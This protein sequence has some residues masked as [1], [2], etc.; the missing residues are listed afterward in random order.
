MSDTSN[1]V[2]HTAMANK[3]TL[4]SVT[5]ETL[6]KDS[7]KAKVSTNGPMDCYIKEILMRE[8]SVGM[9]G[10]PTA[11]NRIGWYMRVILKMG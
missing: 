5:L 4:I 7:S 6:R 11:I 8:Y 9:A 1:A 2:F 3:F 10:L